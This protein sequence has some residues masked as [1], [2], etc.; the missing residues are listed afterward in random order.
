MGDQ[1]N[2]QDYIIEYSSNGTD[3]TVAGS[4]PPTNNGG[5][6]EYH[7]CDPVKRHSGFYRL[8]IIELNGGARYSTV[9]KFS[10]KNESG[11]D[12]FPNPATTKLNMVMPAS[13]SLNNASYVVFSGD[14]RCISAGKL[15]KSFI[16]ITSLPNGIYH[17]R[18]K[19]ETRVLLEKTFIKN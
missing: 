10:G 7:F 17:L 5:Q 14:G 19:N 15:S 3:F 18:V 11:L 4:I 6:A 13:G 1:G 2:V 8:K 16:D 9:L 12:I